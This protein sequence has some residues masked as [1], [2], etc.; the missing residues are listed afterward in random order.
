MTST[1]EPS[2]APAT[3]PVTPLR[4]GATTYVYPT[5]WLD[6][7]RRLAFRVSDIALL[8]YDAKSPPGDEELRGLAEVK[9]RAKL[10]Y[11]VHLPTDI[12]FTHRS[13]LQRHAALNVLKRLARR[14][15]FLDPETYVLH[16][17]GPSRHEATQHERWV[18]RAR[19]GLRALRRVGVPT[20]RVCLQ[21][22]SV[23]DLDAAAEV[24]D[25]TGARLAVDVGQLENEATDWRDRLEAHLARAG[26]I[27]WY[28]H[29]ADER[30]HR[31]VAFF[32]A[33]D[34]EWLLQTLRDRAFDGVLAL[35][36]Y[37]TA[38]FDESLAKLER[39]L[40]RDA[41]PKVSL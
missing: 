1:S 38:D 28:G 5:G 33:R 23:D 30:G 2:A 8:F 22:S 24:A 4:V 35:H 11:T 40:Q 6:N 13:W 34:A 41:R 19:R 20:E 16:I 12:S 25:I 17:E 27:L 7:V 36:I 29:D 3:E 15:R 9:Q 37:R 32:P 18:K 26:V 10:S 21:P 31:S 39:A 14:T